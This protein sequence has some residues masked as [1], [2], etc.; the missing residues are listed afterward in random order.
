MCVFSLIGDLSVMHWRVLHPHLIRGSSLEEVVGFKVSFQISEETWLHEWATPGGG[1]REN[2]KG[3]GVVR[4]P[5]R[6]K[7]RDWVGWSWQVGR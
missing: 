6:L 2:A 4:P 5:A 7:Q 1:E 3:V